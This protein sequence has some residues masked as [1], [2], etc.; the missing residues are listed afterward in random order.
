MNGSIHPTAIIEEGAK[1]SNKAVIGPYCI[2]GAKVVIE[3]GV[4]LHS[5]VNVQGRTTLG[6]N[7]Q[8]FPFAS[9]GTAPQD[10]KY[11]GED[12]ELVI[13]RSL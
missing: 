13:G 5:H 3:D 6:E 9:L 10:L 8:V 12:T 11:D 4:K 2:I 7:T 1:I